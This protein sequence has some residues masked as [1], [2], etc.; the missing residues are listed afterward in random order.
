[1]SITTRS[2]TATDGRSLRVHDAG[3]RDTHSPLH[4]FW[5]H[6]TPGIG[7]PPAPLLPI[8]DELGFQFIGHD[9]PGYG[10][11]G[12]LAGRSIGHAASDVGDIADALGISHYAVMGY[13]G[14][15]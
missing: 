2:V 13:S 10:E 7:Q 14:G 3:A 11:S 12:R 6:G 8:A 1:M 5:H 4:I 15:G 9:R